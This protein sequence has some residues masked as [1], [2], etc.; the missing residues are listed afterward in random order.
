MNRADLIPV[1][2]GDVPADLLLA[3]ARIIN[4]FNG[5]IEPGNVA[6]YQ[7]I[8]AGV[9]DYHRARETI[10][11]E[12]RYLAPGFIDGH[13]HLE[14]SM[15]DVGEYARVVVPR[16]TLSVITD[17]HE[18]ANVAGIAGMKY[19]LNRA[20]RLPLNI[21]LMAPSCVPATH[22]E[23][24]GA[25]L[26]TDSLKQILKW[27]SC[28]GL[29]EMMN[30][31]GV[32]NRD[33]KVLEKLRLA[34]SR[35]VDG[36]AP[37][38][39]GN[40]LS[41]YIAA[42][43]RSDHESVSL[44]EAR[45]KLDKGMYIMIREGSSEKNLEALLPLVTEATCRRCMLVVDDRS[46]VELQQDGDI[47]AVIRK[48]VRLGLNPVQAV[49]MVTLNPAE[50]FNLKNLG[51]VAPGYQADMVAFEDLNNLQA[52]MV[53]SRGKLV[54]RD[55][56]PTFGAGKQASTGLRDTVNIKL[57]GQ[58]DFRITGTNPVPVIEVIPGQII[59]KRR[60]EILDIMDGSFVPDVARDILKIVVVER[61]QATGNVGIG[62]I[63]GFGLK[64]GAL[65]SSVAHDSHNIVA[66]G[67]DDESLYTAVSEIQK[68]KGGLVAVDGKML[69]ASLPL[70]IAGLLSGQ[71]LEKTVDLLSVVEKVASRLG[72][73][74][75]ASFATLSFMALPVIPELKITDL[76]L[77]DVNEFRI[78]R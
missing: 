30:Y 51:A 54:A 46:C 32:I 7:G 75:P 66:V 77:V 28:I 67:A 5:R 39:T 17:L 12:G 11:L 22:L 40:N 24:S 76:G 45:E 14:S 35:P 44:G 26:D 47:D 16:G 69:L 57:S 78:I 61:H 64:K 9:G 52:S 21:F 20:Q 10:N 48:A 70:P 29:G 73:S 71:S 59:T 62:F 37:G 25:R 6:V 68:M 72:S 23:T 15:L 56:H 65:A 27:Q 41:A 13:V 8:V 2:R 55:G 58:N 42:G 33:E 4:V 1:A 50:Y 18:I 34:G 63:T 60:M 49:Q 31:P 36:H 38:L 74:L 53:F 19:V 3:N 43:I